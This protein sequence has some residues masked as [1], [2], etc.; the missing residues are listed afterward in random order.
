MKTSDV[1]RVAYM[2]CRTLDA[3]LHS[4]ISIYTY[5][6]SV[7]NLHTYIYIYILYGVSHSR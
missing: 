5:I 2:T 4:K 7:S 1:W 3:V 6:Y